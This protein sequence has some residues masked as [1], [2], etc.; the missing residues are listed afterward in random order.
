MLLLQNLFPLVQ[1]LVLRHEDLFMN[2]AKIIKKN[3]EENHMYFGNFQIEQLDGEEAILF[4][5]LKL[6]ANEQQKVKVYCQIFKNGDWWHTEIWSILATGIKPE[7]HQDMLET[8]NILNKKFN[9][10]KKAMEYEDKIQEGYFY[11]FLQLALDEDGDV[12]ASHRFILPIFEN[13]DDFLKKMAFLLSWFAN[14]I[15]TCIRNIID[16]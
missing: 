8:I 4:S 13:E 1:E 2:Y 10:F 16:L 9:A 12:L 7:Q 15:N 5:I 6:V 14:G 11:G 3:I